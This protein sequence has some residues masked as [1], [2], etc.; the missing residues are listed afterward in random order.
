MRSFVADW[1]A[2]M[3]NASGRYGQR[4]VSPAAS[5]IFRAAE[6]NIATVATTW[7]LN[8]NRFRYDEKLRGDQLP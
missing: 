8:A 3:S 2:L 7:R 1:R 6:E 5:V 4:D